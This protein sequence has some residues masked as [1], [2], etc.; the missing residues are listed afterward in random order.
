MPN[1]GS[2]RVGVSGWLY[3]E[4][5][6]SFYPRGLPLAQEL[7]Y[8][9]AQFNSIEINGSFY[10]L[11]RPEHFERWHDCTPAD[12]MFAVKGSRYMTHMLKLIRIDAAL[13]N[14]LASGL[15][16]LGRKLGPILWQLPPQVRFDAER[17]RAFLQL[18]PRDTDEAL[19]IARRHDARVKGRCYLRVDFPQRLRHAL[20]IRHDSF[21]TPQFPEL[22]RHYDTALVC[23]DTVEWPLVMD[24]S[25]D[26]VYCRLHGSQ[27]LYVSG[28]DDTA[29][30]H[31]ATRVRAWAR[32]AE[33]RDARRIGKR[34][35]PGAGGRDVFVY[36]DNTAKVSAPENALALAERLGVRQQRVRRKERRSVR[37]HRLSP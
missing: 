2:I 33:P 28:Y 19:R 35:K 30:D 16:R 13:A 7:S 32:G 3:P 36:F 15:L 18:L 6:G 4:W 21:L 12:F 29:L 9:A 8:A 24:L 14:F 25:A 34:C 27:E 1:H 10:R 5:R 23:A 17:L 37:E 26:F 20:E 11:Q 22:L 31:W